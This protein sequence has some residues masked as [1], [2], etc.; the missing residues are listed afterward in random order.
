MPRPFTREGIET[1]IA[2]RTAYEANPAVTHADLRRQFGV[3]QQMVDSAMAK[4]ATEWR[5]MLDTAP[6]STPRVEKPRSESATEPAREPLALP[7]IEQGIVKFTRRPAKMGTDY[8][9]WIPRVYVRNGLVDVS[10]E[11][12]VFL[13]KKGVRNTTRHS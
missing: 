5:A 6:A 7:G 2:I 3:M 8:I 4:T 12:E 13:V 9:F 10:T 1:R 11:Y